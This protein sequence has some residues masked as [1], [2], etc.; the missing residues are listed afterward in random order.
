MSPK[1]TANTLIKTFETNNPFKLCSYLDIH[2]LHHDLIDIRGYY[3]YEQGLN[4]IVIAKNLPDFVIEFVCAHELGHYML[5]KGLNRIFMD[6]RTFMVP[7]KYE[8]QADT[9]AAYLL[10]DTQPIFHDRFL[11]DW[12]LAQCLNVPKC[13]LDT[14]LEQLHLI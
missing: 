1:H 10:Y 3:V 13:N 4:Y 5:H 8:N 2:I 9:F 11:S 14:R 7:D 6:S 12:E